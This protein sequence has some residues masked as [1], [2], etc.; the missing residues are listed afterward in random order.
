MNPDTFK[1]MIDT[2]NT[3]LLEYKYYWNIIDKV[4]TRRSALK[5][6]QNPNLFKMKEL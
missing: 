6:K 4:L 5:N 2:L 1:N 3:V